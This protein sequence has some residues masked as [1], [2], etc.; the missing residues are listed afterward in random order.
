MDVLQRHIYLLRGADAE[1]NQREHVQMTVDEGGPAVHEERPAA[2]EHDGNRLSLAAT[3]SATSR[4]GASASQ[5]SG[6]L[7]RR[8]A[9]F[10]RFVVA[11]SGSMS[12]ERLPGWRSKA[13]RVASRS[14][15]VGSS[16]ADA[17]I[18]ESV[19]VTWR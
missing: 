9:V 3:V 15:A 5:G 1:G 10:K 16:N 6:A 4:R 2:P 12:G 18:T 14:N 8:P 11:E 17:F 19:A 7:H 13:M